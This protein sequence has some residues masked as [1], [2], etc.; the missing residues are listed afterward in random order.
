MVTEGVT[1][2]VSV[3]STSSCEAL[4]GLLVI[5]HRSV[6]ATPGVP[7]NVDVGLEAFPKE[8][9]AP[10]TLV[11]VPVPTVGELPASVTNVS[12]QVD[13]PI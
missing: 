10:L 6:Y 12:P 13:D 11:Q 5:V 3:T 4:Q 7:V 2:G 1:F 8:P 9:P